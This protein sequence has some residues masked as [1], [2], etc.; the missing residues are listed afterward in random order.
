M[1]PLQLLYCLIPT[2]KNITKVHNHLFYFGSIASPSSP[3]KDGSLGNKTDI[4][5]TLERRVYIEQ[6]SHSDPNWETYH[7]WSS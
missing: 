3:I 7:A 5:K 6:Q 2:V 4:T 1:L